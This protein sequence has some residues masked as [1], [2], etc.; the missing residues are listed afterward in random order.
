[1]AS[2][3][4]SASDKKRL[5]GGNKQQLTSHTQH[6]EQQEEQTPALCSALSHGS[7]PSPR[8][9]HLYTPLAVHSFMEATNRG[10]VQTKG[11]FFLVSCLVF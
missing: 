4:P 3:M 8:P 5:S 10:M 7:A 6:D 1:M 9:A 11:F 2:F